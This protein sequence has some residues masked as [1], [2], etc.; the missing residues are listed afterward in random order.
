MKNASPRTVYLK[1]YTPPAFLIDEVTLR[2]ELGEDET[3]VH[4]RLALRRNPAAADAK[5]PLVLD[6]EQLTLRALRIDGR[7][8]GADD[9]LLDDTSL[10]LPRPPA[11]FTL[12]TVT[13][14]RPK[15]N[16]ALEGLY[17]SSGNFCTQC[18]A[19]GFRKITYFLDRPDVMA[20]YTTTVVADAQ[21]YPVLLSNGNPVERGTLE[22]GRHFVTW[23]DPHPK[24]SYL[25]ALVAGD[26]VCREDRFVTR[27][28]R[29]VD[30]RIYVEAHNLDK[31]EHAMV[32]LK[33]AMAWDEER[34]GREYDL[35]IY[36]IVAVDDFNMGAME[37]KGL[38]VFNSKYVL[39]RPDT[40][41]DADFLG[42]ESVIAH[43]YFHNW[44][45][46]RVTCRDWFQLSLKEGLT[47]FRDQEFSADLNS[48]AVQRID[49]V[50]MLRTHQFAE[51]AGPMAHPVRPQSYMEINN[52][53]TVT[54]YEK[55]AEVV[56][57]YQTL[58]GREGFRKGM[59]LYFERHDGQAV[60]TED[61]CAAMA[62]AN[63]VDLTQ[64]KR[65]YD[66]AGT[67][68]LHVQGAWDAEARTYTLTV[69]Q[70]CP[71]TPGQ[72][73]K[74]PFLIPLEVGLVGPDGRDLPLRLEG[75]TAAVDGS[76]VLTLDAARGEY[77]FVDVPARPVPSLLRHF[78]APVKLHYDYTE[79]EL[80]FLM[81]QDSD[82]FNRWEAAQELA[83]RTVAGLLEDHHHEHA[84]GVEA[85]V[86]EAYR[87]VLEDRDA[88][89]ALTAEALS[90]PSESYLAERFEPID[91]GAIHDVRRF[92][93]HTLASAL[94]DVLVHAYRELQETGDYRLD[95]RSVGRRRLKSVCLGYLTELGDAQDFALALAQY[96][97]ATNMTDALG[98]LAALAD[99]DCPERDEALE[100]FEGRW[101]AEPLV[102]DKWFALQAGSSLPGTLG[103]VTRLMGHPAFSLKNPN[104]VRALIGAFA[105]NPSAFHAADGSGYA[106]V[107]DQVLAL[108]PMNPQVASRLT[109]GFTRWRRYEPR[110]AALMRAQL[111]RIAG[112]DGLSRDVFEVASKSLAD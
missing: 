110:R 8:L 68:E 51:D 23:H 54:V 108:D 46:N 59:D 39:A 55:G 87:A 41:T 94:R 88:D 44:T 99:F 72:T 37:N 9:Y 10:T 35:D 53:Y 34:F 85:E 31:T 42:I 106:F 107:A 64:F 27:S 71:P 48:A 26:L 29:A 89:P 57:M 92:F 2:F 17:T 50:R 70:S 63:G 75:E 18:E 52:F 97:T 14:I 98:A 78:S 109:K 103:V 56:R 101:Y 81:A 112:T 86:A 22:G 102:M 84:L 28:G 60:T 1:D 100:D 66:Q 47:V 77:R 40:A 20:V 21:R 73:E 32:S 7:E 19:E 3:L 38:N 16:T 12:E 67:P 15:E 74:Q 36:M 93:R 91:P 96:R 104:R 33:K 11:A 24:P 43:E 62:D 4:A 30:L 49:D 76:R 69:E 82:P 80:R 90:L 111:E 79:E 61:F 65:W 13:A 95:P 6:G 105:A 83:V 58:L 45:G 5:A 25:F